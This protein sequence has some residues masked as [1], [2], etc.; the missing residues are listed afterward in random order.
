MPSS[1]VRALSFITPIDTS[2]NYD[3]IPSS[4]DSFNVNAAMLPTFVAQHVDEK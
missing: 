4:A 2:R 1:K 3:V